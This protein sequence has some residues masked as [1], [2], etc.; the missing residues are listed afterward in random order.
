MFVSK[1]IRSYAVDMVKQASACLNRRRETLIFERGVNR[2]KPVLLLFPAH[3]VFNCVILRDSTLARKREL[4]DRSQIFQNA[5]R[6]ARNNL[7]F[8]RKV[9][10]ENDQ[11][12]FQTV[13]RFDV[14]GIVARFRSPT[15]F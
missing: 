12:E 2:L 15:G 14:G 4:F 10:R 11:H 5:A 8:V 3:F 7:A 9:F 6:D 13:R 1:R